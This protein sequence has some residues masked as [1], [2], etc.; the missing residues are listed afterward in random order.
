[1]RLVMPDGDDAT[2]L[3][4]ADLERP[5]SGIVLTYRPKADKTGS[6]KFRCLFADGGFGPDRLRVTAIV[7]PDGSHLGPL[8]LRYLRMKLNLR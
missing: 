4:Q 8:S 6:R 3:D 1:M 5:E 7:R 2:V